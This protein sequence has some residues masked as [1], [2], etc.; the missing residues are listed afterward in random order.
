MTYWPG[1][2]SVI[3]KKK[4]VIGHNT[5]ISLINVKSHLLILKKQKPPP[6]I[7]PSTSK[8]FFTLH[9]SFIA[10]L[11]YFL[12][13]NP[14][15]H[16][17]SNLH[18]YWFFNSSAIREMRVGWMFCKLKFLFTI[19]LWYNRCCFHLLRPKERAPSESINHLIWSHL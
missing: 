11:Y 16:V 14:T 13:K 7:P 4:S 12:Q 2:S 10:V 17:Y 6:T 19:P 18:I 1:C 8:I 15:L 3:K 9:S 5:L